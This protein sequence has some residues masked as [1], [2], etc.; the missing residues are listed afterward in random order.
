MPSG[1]R[2]RLPPAAPQITI[3]PDFVWNFCFRFEMTENQRNAELI[4]DSLQKYCSVKQARILDICCGVY[5][6]TGT[7][8][9]KNGEIYEPVVAQFLGQN[10]YE[11]TGI[12]FRQN[13]LVQKLFYKP[14]TNIDILD[15]NWTEKIQKNWDVLI[16]LRSWDTPEILLNYQEKLENS[17]LNE[18]CIQIAEDL[19]PNFVDLINENGL[20]FTTEIF[21]FGLLQNVAETDS[22]LNLSKELFA[23]NNLEILDYQNGLYCLRKS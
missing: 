17:Y 18:L 20:L 16:F 5:D 8:Y 22:Y 4:L 1:L 14:I 10:G 9:D 12:D 23:K 2:V 15:Q 13:S 6:K 19:L 3:N 21:N 7:S 11:V